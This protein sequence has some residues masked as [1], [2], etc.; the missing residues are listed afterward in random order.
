MIPAKPRKP[1]ELAKARALREQGQSIKRIARA[2]GVSPSSVRLWTSDIELA[3]EQVTTT[4]RGPDG[5]WRPERLRAA[6]AARSANAR[7][8]RAE[9]QEEGRLRAREGDLLH[10]AGCMLYW[11]EG[12]KDRNVVRLTNSDVR[13]VRLF[14]AFLVSR[15]GVDRADIRVSLNAY[16][17]NGLTIGAIEAHWLDA[18]GLPRECVRKH[19]LDQRP[20]SS[21]G[22]AR[23]KLPYG[24]CSLTVPSTRAVQHIYGAIQEYVGF[25]EPA[26]LA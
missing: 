25:D 22:G 26:W 2:L 8:R 11:A 10:H 13:M 19:R 14:C 3:P 12:S 23:G 15:I 7:A 16:T 24:V 5:P 6:V 20:T 4:L 18:L 9:H 1:D 17:D 21:S